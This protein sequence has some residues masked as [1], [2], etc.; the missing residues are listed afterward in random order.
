MADKT[1]TSIWLVGAI[2]ALILVIGFSIIGTG[3]TK[4]ELNNELSSLEIPTAE[5]I[6]NLI[7]VPEAPEVVIPEFKSD[8]KVTD[9][10]NDLYSVEIDELETEAEN[11]A[12]LELE[13][14]NFEILENYLKVNIE[15]FDELKDVDYEDVEAK[16][17][18]LGLEDD[19]DKIAEVVFELKIKYTLEEGQVTSYKKSVFATA[20][21][22]FEEGDFNDEKV[23]FN[24]AFK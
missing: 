9:L 21:V 4:T 13:D 7:V 12:T 19:E 1:I 20:N 18:A 11:A 15:E 10:W 14:N 6:A 5:E 2:L 16:V 8:N 22:L 17:I 24:F 3:I 23:D